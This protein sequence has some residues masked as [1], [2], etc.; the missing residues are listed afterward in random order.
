M[1]NDIYLSSGCER[2]VIIFGIC[3]SS[4]GGRQAMIFDNSVSFNCV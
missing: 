3:I 4:D 2:R 1:I